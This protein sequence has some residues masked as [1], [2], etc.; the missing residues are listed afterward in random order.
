[1]IYICTALYCEAKPIINFYHLKKNLNIKKFDVFENENIILFITKL[2]KLNSAIAISYILSMKNI[3]Y[4]DLFL[5]IGTCACKN[6]LY[7]LGTPI[8]INKIVDYSMNKVFYPDIIFEHN[9]AED[10]IT[11]FDKVIEDEKF[12]ITNTLIDMEA[13]GIYKAASIFFKQHNIIFIKIVSDYCN[14]TNICSEYITKIIEQNIRNIFQILNNFQSTLVD[15][16]INFSDKEQ[17]LINKLANNLKLSVTMLYQLKQILLYYKLKT[18]I[19]LSDMLIQYIEDTNS[20]KTKFNGK[21]YF[22][23]IKQDIL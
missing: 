4:N 20:C 10:T 21:I 11:T 18:N 23:K 16:T 15:N 14:I 17:S 13:S 19:D 7:E 5:N 12:N 22:N 3:N 2:G 8:V 1:M 6:D 9:F